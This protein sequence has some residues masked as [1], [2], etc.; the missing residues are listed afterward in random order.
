MGETTTDMDREIETIRQKYTIFEDKKG[1]PDSKFV[2]EMNKLYLNKISSREKSDRV[3][4][5][6]NKTQNTHKFTKN[7]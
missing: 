4:E 1:I 7:L 2:E 3:M 6:L 5:R